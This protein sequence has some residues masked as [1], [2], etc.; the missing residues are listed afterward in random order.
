MNTQRDEFFQIS[1]TYIACLVLLLRLLP[2]F[3]PFLLCLSLCVCVDFFL[4]HLALSLNL[5]LMCFLLSF[6]IFLLCVLFISLSLAFLFLSSFAR[7]FTFLY[8]I[9]ISFLR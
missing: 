6:P 1:S 7:L 4:R 9:Q 2:T 3:H 5:L 8:E